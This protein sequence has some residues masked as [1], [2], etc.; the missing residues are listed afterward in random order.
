M[1]TPERRSVQEF[2][3]HCGFSDIIFII[4]YF[5][6]FTMATGTNHIIELKNMIDGPQFK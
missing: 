1:A 6:F 3:G 5:E 2:N 4:A